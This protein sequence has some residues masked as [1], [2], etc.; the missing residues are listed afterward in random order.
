MIVCVI[1]VS[2]KSISRVE[3]WMK[4]LTNNV[5]LMERSPFTDPTIKINM[6][7]YIC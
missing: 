1:R 4:F 7:L 3:C 2:D 5:M 6:E